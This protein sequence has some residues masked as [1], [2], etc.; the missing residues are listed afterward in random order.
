MDDELNYHLTN[1]NI[2]PLV[3]EPDVDWNSFSG[4]NIID[5]YWSNSLFFWSEEHARKYRS[6]RKQIDGHY[7]TLEQM[8]K[9]IPITQGAL[10]AFEGYRVHP[11]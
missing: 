2:T 4:S 7:L 1:K 11:G 9:T 8:A 6:A 5:A 3:F 10:F